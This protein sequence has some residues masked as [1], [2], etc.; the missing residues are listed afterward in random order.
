MK[1]TSVVIAVLAAGTV[2]AAATPQTTLP[3]WCG[4]IGQGCKRT[5]DASVDVKRSADALAEAM[6]KN[7]PLVLQKWCGHIGQGCYKAKRAADAVD[8]VKRRGRGVKCLLYN[9][10]RG[11]ATSIEIAR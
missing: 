9:E 7:L 4:H 11:A 8:E 3:K 2:Q 1:F 5:T 6:A 10:F